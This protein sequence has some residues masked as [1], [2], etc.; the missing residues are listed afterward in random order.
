MP[1]ASDHLIEFKKKNKRKQKNSFTQ[2]IVTGKSQIPTQYENL[3]RGC[4]KIL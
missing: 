2:E 4:L 1:L 3:T